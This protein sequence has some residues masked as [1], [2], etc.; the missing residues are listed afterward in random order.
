MTSSSETTAGS[1]RPLCHLVEDNL[2]LVPCAYTVQLVKLFR[3]SLSLSRRPMRE[4][5]KLPFVFEKREYT[6]RWT[7]NR[8]ACISCLA[9]T[10]LFVCHLPSAGNWR[11]KKEG[12]KKKDPR[13]ARVPSP[14]SSLR[15][16]IDGWRVRGRAAR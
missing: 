10:F 13:A 1:I 16:I 9:V 6:F 4:D 15:E 14:R 12:E 2:H 5:M 11:E 3:P 8:T 7:K